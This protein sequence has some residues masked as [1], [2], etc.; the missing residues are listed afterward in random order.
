MY[1]TDARV[2]TKIDSYV[3][4]GTGI[5]VTSGEIDLDNTAVTAGSY[6]SSSAVP[7][8]TV[9][10]QGRITA[11]GTASFNKLN[12]PIRRCGR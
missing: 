6:G 11:A 8:F 2:E 1:Y 4:G 12:N 9:D 3:T 7:T 10:A 5:S